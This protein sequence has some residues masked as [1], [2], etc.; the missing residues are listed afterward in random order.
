[1]FSVGVIFYET[2]A[3]MIRVDIARYLN[4]F[5]LGEYILAHE[6]IGL[7]V[8]HGQ[9]K[10]AILGQQKLPSKE[11]EICLKLLEEGKKMLR[12]KPCRRISAEKAATNLQ[13][14][15]AAL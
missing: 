7:T 12:F 10:K 2:A 3:A 14:F 13:K 15:L 4:R 6:K 11:R 9:L 8:I 5:D 1:M